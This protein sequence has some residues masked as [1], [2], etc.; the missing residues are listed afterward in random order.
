[1]GRTS[2]GNLPFGSEMAKQLADP[3]WDLCV[4]GESCDMC[5]CGGTATCFYPTPSP[6]GDLALRNKGRNSSIVT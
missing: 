5:D 1:M 2:L 4:S 3:K 6:L